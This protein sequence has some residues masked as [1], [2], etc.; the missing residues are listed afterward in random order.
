MK[1]VAHF[2]ITRFNLRRTTQEVKQLDPGWL[3]SRFDLFDRFCFP[4]VRGQTRQDFRWLVLFDSLTPC[5]VLPRIREYQRW[6]AF[7]PVFFPAGSEQQAR[8]AVAERVGAVPDLLVTTRLDN[9][10]GVCR[11]FVEDIR[12]HVDVASATVLEFPVGY[13]WHK[14]RVYLDRQRLNPF[15]T[16]VEPLGGRAGAPFRTIYGGAHHDA[17][18][19]GR[20]VEVSRRPSWLQ[21]VHDDNRANHVRGVRSPLRDLSAAF[22]IELRS[23]AE[24]ESRLSLD[25][26][27]AWT[28]ARAG[29][30][31][32]WLAAR[33]CVKRCCGWQR[34]VTVRAPGRRA[35]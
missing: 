35:A 15:T 23:L 19:L 25:L 29:T 34:G 18:D 5:S 17:A 10:D 7:V 2:I 20:I 32:A 11:T 30:S 22:D 8:S 31:R 13:V 21:V 16:L 27:R 3:A 1:S 4:T 6:A 9:D 12:R 24:H 14:D 28:M 33:G 26:D